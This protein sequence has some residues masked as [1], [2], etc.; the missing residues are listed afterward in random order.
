MTDREPKPA[1]AQSWAL[2]LVL[3]AIWGASFLFIGIAVKELSAL[4]IVLARVGI[5]AAILLPLHLVM[6]GKLPF[7]SRTLVASLG[8]SLLNSVLPFTLITWG[9]HHVSASIASVINATTPMFAVVFMA[10]AGYEG[11]TPRKVLALAVGLGGVIVLKGGLADFGS[12]QSLGV[13][14]VGLATMFYGLSAPFSKKMLD[15]IAPLT[16]ATWMML[17]SSLIML[18]AVVLLGNPREFLMASQGTWAAL[19]ALAALSSSLAY[20]L[21]FRIIARAGPSFGALCTMIIPVFAILL[22]F[23]FLG[24]TLEAHEVAGALGIGLALIIIDGRLLRKA[25]L[26]RA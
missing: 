19:I 16:T 26:L 1:D 7:D 13:F 14:A 23:V 22:A 6:V 11:I 10:L 18:L 5:A 21:F 12:A 4:Q 17:W 2:L 3:S 25:G 20:I 9:Q 24:E 15:G 8:M